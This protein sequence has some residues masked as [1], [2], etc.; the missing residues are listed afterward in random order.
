[1][2]P[3]AVPRGFLRMYIISL[4]SRSPET[5]YSIMRHI[6]EKTEG[7]WRPGPGTIYPLLKSM[8]REGLIASLDHGGRQDS[9][10]YS[11]T[12]KGKQELSDMQ[13][14]MLERG[15]EGQAL[16]GLVGELFPPSHYAQFF[17]KHY[18]GEHKL[19][20]EKVLELPPEERD[21]TLK[22]VQSVLE[23]QLEWIRLQLPHK[24]R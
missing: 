8:S 9:V 2:G 12:E 6:D 17:I 18:K 3:Q 4:V 7:T 10:A 1:M 16:M 14:R 19:F 15:T 11:V 21:A 24:A 23:K 20:A 5:G 22:E 13:R